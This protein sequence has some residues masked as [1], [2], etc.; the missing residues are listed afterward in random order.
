MKTK[1]GQTHESDVGNFKSRS[2]PGAN[3]QNA[4]S[5]RGHSSN[6]NSGK[7]SGSKYVLK[8]VQLSSMRMGENTST[9]AVASHQHGQ[10]QQSNNE[11]G[12][13]RGSN[14]SSGPPREQAWRSSDPKSSQASTTAGQR[15]WSSVA[16]HSSAPSVRPS[17]STL[18]EAN[19]PPLAAD[20]TPVA[21]EP[22][23]KPQGAGFWIQ[24]QGSL[25]L[26][27]ALQYI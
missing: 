10:L 22:L 1:P 24:R 13:W 12:I 4:N 2:G 21:Q 7:I 16:G 20:G 8:P 25:H 23:L 11:S 26:L 5:R 18:G 17:G 19:F 15:S 27:F 9:V 6:V 3:P 14:V